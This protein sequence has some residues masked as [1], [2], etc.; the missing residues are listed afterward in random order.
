MLFFNM[1]VY[2]ASIYKENLKN[3]TYCLNLQDTWNNKTRCKRILFIS[4][5]AKSDD[6][7]DI[8]NV[9][10]STVCQTI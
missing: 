2:R 6:N 8:L 7:K 3:V 9:S 1:S 4:T 5:C 10:N